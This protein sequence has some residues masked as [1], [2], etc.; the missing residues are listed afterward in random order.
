MT[1]PIV[2]LVD[3]IRLVISLLPP[4][5]QAPA[6]VV[7]STLASI[8]TI[9]SLITARLPLSARQHPRY[10]W[11]VRVLHRVSLL[12]LRDERGTTKLPGAVVEERVTVAP[13][14]RETAAQLGDA[15]HVTSPTSAVLLMGE[16]ALASLPLV[17]SA[18][19][20]GAGIVSE[21]RGAFDPAAR[22]TIAPDVVAEAQRLT[23]ESERGFVTVRALLAVVV[24]LAV[25]LPLSAALT[26]CPLTREASLI[27]ARAPS[28]TDCRPG[29]QRCMTTPDGYVPVVCSHVIALDGRHREWPA[30]PR[31]PADGRQRTCLHGCVVD[32][33]GGVAHCVGL[34]TDGGVR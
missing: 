29:A 22:Q 25:V 16:V 21:T 18:G 34:A 1:D 4:T 30:L 2:D 10:G 20:E 15:V 26:G 5:W 14:G 19:K 12:R 27:A 11:A 32:A 23:R 3:P 28:P 6:A 13:V 24:L 31:D 7:V 8:V 17:E 33:D 9:A